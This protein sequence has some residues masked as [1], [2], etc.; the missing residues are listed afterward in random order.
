MKVENLNSGHRAIIYAV[1]DTN[2]TSYSTDL[3]IT[4]STFLY[5]EGMTFSLALSGL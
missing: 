5:N 3:T 4:D 1:H 2:T